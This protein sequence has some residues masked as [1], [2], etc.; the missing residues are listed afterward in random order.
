MKF[1]PIYVH[2]DW[3]TFSGGFEQFSVNSKLLGLKMQESTFFKKQNGFESR[4]EFSILK[5]EQ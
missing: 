2:F 3:Q 1:L 4:V 5:E